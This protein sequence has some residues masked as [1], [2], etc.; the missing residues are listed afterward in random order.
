MSTGDVERALMKFASGNPVGHPIKWPGKV[1]DP[2]GL[3][4][5][6]GEV[7]IAPTNLNR[8]VRGSTAPRRINGSMVLTVLRAVKQGQKLLRSDVD[9]LE[10]Y[11]NWRQTINAGSAPN[12]FDVCLT[13]VSVSGII[14]GKTWSSKALTVSWVS[15]IPAQ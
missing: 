3:P 6:R 8:Q 2:N 5:M 9:Q 10:S 15:R 14:E 13:G 12:Q 7:L 4:W 11:L 1:F